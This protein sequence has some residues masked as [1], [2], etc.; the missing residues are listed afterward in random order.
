MYNVAC[1]NSE[2][3]CGELESRGGGGGE[4]DGGSERRWGGER[5][6]VWGWGEKERERVRKPSPEEGGI[7]LVF[8]AATVKFSF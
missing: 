7:C 5:K 8:D 6:R 3:F 2:Q 1:I 4:R